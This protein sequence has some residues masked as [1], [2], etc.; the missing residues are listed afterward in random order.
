MAA[1]S[2]TIF[3]HSKGGSLSLD[4]DECILTTSQGVKISVAYFPNHLSMF[5]PKTSA[6]DVLDNVFKSSSI[7]KNT[8]FPVLDKDNTNLTDY[9]KE[10]LA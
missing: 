2:T 9:Q 3:K 8:V 5:I 6:N 1:T 7:M 10:Q 4:K